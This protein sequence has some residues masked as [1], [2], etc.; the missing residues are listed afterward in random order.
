M[1]VLYTSHLLNGAQLRLQKWEINVTFIW[2]FHRTSAELSDY[3]DSNQGYQPSFRRMELVG[4][5]L[6][7]MRTNMGA[8]KRD[9]GGKLD[10]CSHAPPPPHF[11]RANENW[12]REGNALVLVA[13]SVIHVETY[14]P[15][16]TR[17]NILTHLMKKP[18][19]CS[20]PWRSNNNYKK[21]KR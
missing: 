18:D 9:G 12:N 8:D 1:S 15:R 4:V 14:N 16:A 2:R 3:G 21:V 13:P 17:N 5:V 6:I 19:A 11:G 10:M 7:E 20:H